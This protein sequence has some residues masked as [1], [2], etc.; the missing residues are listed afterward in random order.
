MKKNGIINARLI[1]EI[2]G[3]GHFDTFVICD[4]GFPIPRDA[5]KIDLALING[6]PSFMQTLKAVLGDVIVQKVTLMDGI[7][8]ANPYLHSEICSL[9]VRQEIEYLSFNDFR[10]LSKNVKF[11]I[12]TAEYTPCANMILVSASGVEERAVKYNIEV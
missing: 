7:K 9:M 1:E 2:A 6:I 8:E 4:S 12:R 3:L 11:F 5:F 10:T